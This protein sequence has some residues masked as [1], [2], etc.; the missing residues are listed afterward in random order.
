[1]VIGRSENRGNL[2]A[3]LSKAAGSQ[4]MVKLFNNLLQ[5]MGNVLCG[6]YHQGKG[7]MS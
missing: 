1:A 3:D 4:C 7:D 6:Q 5:K 2:K